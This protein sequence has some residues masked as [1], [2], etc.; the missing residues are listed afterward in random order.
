MNQ[1]PDKKERSSF[2]KLT[3]AMKKIFFKKSKNEDKV[4]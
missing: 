3:T 2:S 1:A 4:E